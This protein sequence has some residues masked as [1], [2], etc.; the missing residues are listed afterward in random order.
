MLVALPD[1]VRVGVSDWETEGVAIA[2]GV[3]VEDM[4]ID[5]TWLSV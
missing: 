4:L 5:G 3:S 2:L 1:T